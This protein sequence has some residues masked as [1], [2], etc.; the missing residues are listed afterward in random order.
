LNKSTFIIDFCVFIKDNG[1]GHTII[2]Y[3]PRLLLASRQQPVINF[4][5]ANYI[6]KINALTRYTEFITGTIYKQIKCWR[7]RQHQQEENPA[8]TQTKN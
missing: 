2:K 5:K 7:G 8:E 4:L 6:F 3:L 1:M